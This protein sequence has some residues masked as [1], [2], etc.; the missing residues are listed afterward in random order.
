MFRKSLIIWAVTKFKFYASGG[1][2]A[3]KA[4]KK[5]NVNS[6]VLKTRL[7]ILQLVQ[8]AFEEFCSGPGMF[9]TGL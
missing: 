8:Y 6:E 9:R 7:K 2:D 3:I 5:M 1:R 4:R